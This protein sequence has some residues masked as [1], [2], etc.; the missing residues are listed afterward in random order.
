M[1][2]HVYTTTKHGRFL[3]NYYGLKKKEC[4]KAADEFRKHPEVI[5]VEV[6]KEN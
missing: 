2:W 6:V 5:K 3:W 1:K 4:E